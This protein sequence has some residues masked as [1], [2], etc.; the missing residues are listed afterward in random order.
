MSNVLEKTKLAAKEGRFNS[1]N[2]DTQSL[3]RT[4][5]QNYQEQ[6]SIGR[7]ISDAISAQDQLSRSRQ[8]VAQNAATIDR[9]MNGNPPQKQL[10]KG[11]EFSRN[12]EGDSI[13]DNIKTQ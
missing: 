5:S 7:E 4:L 12:K 10:P 8:Y 1:S 6:E 9:N 11:V 13:N 2:S 3:A